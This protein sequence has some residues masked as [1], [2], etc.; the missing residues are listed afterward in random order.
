MSVKSAGRILAAMERIAARGERPTLRKV[1]ADMI[2]TDG[3]GA[4]LSTIQPILAAWKRNRPDEESYAVRA[5]RASSSNRAQRRQLIDT[6]SDFIDQ[7]IET[8]VLTTG[9]YTVVSRIDALGGELAAL[10]E[11]LRAQHDILEQLTHQ[12]AELLHELQHLTTFAIVNKG[13]ARKN[14]TGGTPNTLVITDE[15]LREIQ[16]LSPRR[17]SNFV[18]GMLYAAL[19]VRLQ[20]T[21]DLPAMTKRELIDA[22]PCLLLGEIQRRNG[23]PVDESYVRSLLRPRVER[24]RYVCAVANGRYAAIPDWRERKSAARGAKAFESFAVQPM[25]KLETEV[26]SVTSS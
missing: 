13:G 14:G 20:R 2:A 16:A 6:L 4:S 5:P 10:R 22:L 9:T 1:R 7:R 15:R 26:G 12:N 23:R 19:L 25:P 18:V 8:H 11:E 21:P 24:Q 3:P 17:F